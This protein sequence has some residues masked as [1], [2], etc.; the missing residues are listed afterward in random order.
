M[1][2]DDWR[3]GLEPGPEQRT[4]RYHLHRLLA[5]DRPARPIERVHASDVIDDDGNWCPRRVALM[6][7]DGVTPAKE[8]MSTAQAVVFGHST[9]VADRL[10]DWLARANIAVGN[11]VCLACDR[12]HAFCLRPRYCDRCGVR[13]ARRFRYREMVVTSRVS[14]I[15]G[16]IDLL[17]KLPGEPL[18][19]VVEIKGVQKSDFVSL[20]MPLGK[21]RLRT[22]LYLRLVEESDHP[23]RHLVDT[24]SGLIIYVVKGGYGVRSDEPRAWG[25]DDA[26]WEPFKEFEVERDDEALDRFSA[27]AATILAWK[28]GGDLPPFLCETSTC[29]R[30]RACEVRVPCWNEA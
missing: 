21:H 9:D 27:A 6:Q 29:P 16:G 15:S 18:V 13:G 22:N 4:L 7:R 28:A 8:R 17:A 26:P 1:P 30:A 3:S 10:I 19:K 11:W 14:G 25:I 24:R 20:V 12:V 23:F 5:Q 2:G